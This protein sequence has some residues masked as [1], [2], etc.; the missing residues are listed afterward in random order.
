MGAGMSFN[1]K[2]PTPFVSTD[3]LSCVMTC[4]LDKKFVR[5]GV[6]GSYKCVY[7][8]DPEI[9]VDL[10]TVGSVPFD[11][12]TLQ[13]LQA[14]NPQKFAEFTAEQ[15]RFNQALATVYANI[16]SATKVSDAFR[17]LQKAENARDQSPSAYQAARTAY[18]TLLKGPSWLAEERARI[19]R[20]EVGPEIQQY[21]TAVSAAALRT[22]E[23]QKTIDVV[24]GIKDKVLSL[25]GDV[26]Y[27]VN[28]FSDQLEKVKIQLNMANRSRKAEAD[29]SWSWV[30]MA[31][32]AALIAILLY[33]IYTFVRRANTPRPP[34]II[35]GTPAYTPRPV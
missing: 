21:R 35:V 33:A 13:Q 28:T 17:D 2:C 5:Q 24:N 23:Q 27:S 25:K 18:Y 15:T 22:Q 10:V 29:T 30:D 26:K 3:A 19:S 9:T 16:D 32:N 1:I 31:L 11:G 4:P 20:A 34:T 6:S 7:S 8:P 12:T 14:V